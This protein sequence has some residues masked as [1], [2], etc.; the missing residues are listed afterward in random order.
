MTTVKIIIPWRSGC[1]HREAALSTVKAWWTINYPQWP[2]IIGEWP[3]S[4]GPWRKGCAVRRAMETSAPTDLVVV[5]DADLLVPGIGEAVQALETGRHDWTVPFRHVHRLTPE[6]TALLLDGRLQLPTDHRGIT[7]I[8]HSYVGSPGG[9]CVALTSEALS[10]Y[11]I[12]PRFAGYGQEDHSWA[13]L[14]Y[15]MLGA[16]HHAFQAALWHLWHPAQERLVSGPTVSMGVGSIES[17]RLWT[18]YRTAVTKSLM[19]TLLEEA[20]E[21]YGIC[22]G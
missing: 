16:P 7:R 3:A 13:R 22:S 18:R 2:V 17:M 21:A 11:P 4:L 5:S 20:I 10:A 1:P 8:A 19:E 15:M 12:D 14:L 6:A 9:G